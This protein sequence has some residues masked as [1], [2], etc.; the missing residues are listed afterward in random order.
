[1]R[2]TRTIHL[3]AAAAA[4]GLLAT[5]TF[6]PSASAAVSCS[7]AGTVVTVTMT[8]DG[9]QATFLRG[10]GR[11]ILVN[12]AQC[13]TATTENTQTV[14]VTGAAGGQEV[15]IDLAGGPFV[16]LQRETSPPSGT[17]VQFQVDDLDPE[18]DVLSVDGTAAVD[19][20]V[21][22]ENG[23]TLSTSR[24]RA[25]PSPW[26]PGRRAARERTP[27]PASSACAARPSR[28]SSAG[29]VQSRPS[30]G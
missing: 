6:T 16:S 12:G 14:T 10:P 22:G 11:E 21:A 1:M 26:P 24:P 18:E 15:F 30:S 2:R 9:D 4:A 28:T 8:A 3:A 19:T 29:A 23:I 27:S 7:Q 5:A 20:F 13:G 17:S 25:S